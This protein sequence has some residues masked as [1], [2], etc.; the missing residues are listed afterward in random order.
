[1]RPRRTTRPETFLIPG[2]ILILSAL[3]LGVLCW[4]M[5]LF[6]KMSSSSQPVPSL[7]SPTG[8]SINPTLGFTQGPVSSP[9]QPERTLAPGA[10]LIGV[11]TPSYALETPGISP[12]SSVD[13]EQLVAKM[14]LEEKVGQ[15]IMT[16]LEG[17]TLSAEAKSL[18]RD[19]HI[20]GV[21]YFGHNIQN[22]QQ[23]LRL[24]QDLQREAAAAG[25]GIPLLIAVDHEGGSVFRFKDS[26]THFP[27]AMTLGAARMPELARQVGIAQARELR[28][29]GVNLNLAPVMD[30]NDEPLNPVIGVRALAGIPDL[31]AQVGVAYLQGLQ[32]AGVAATA[33]HFPGHGSTRIDSHLALAVVNKSADELQRTDLVPFRAAVEAGVE[34][35]MVGHI[36]V[37]AVDASR[38]PASLSGPILEGLLRQ[39]LSYRGVVMSDAM[40]MGAVTGNYSLEEAAVRAVNAGCDIL[41]YTSSEAALA[42]HKAVLAAVRNGSIPLEKVDASVRRILALKQR[43][44]LFGSLPNTQ[45]VDFAAD[46]ALAKFLAHQAIAASGP[47]S[48][49][50]V[51]VN[52]LVL[53]TPDNLPV[54]NVRGD[55]LSLLGE[56]LTRQGLE[57]DE[58]IYSLE[59]PAQTAQMQGLTMV[60]LR[61][62]PLAV[63]VTWDARLKQEGGNS[64]QVEFVQALSRSGKPFILVAGN[65]PYDLTLTNGKGLALFGGLSYQ[66]EALAEAF[67]APTAPPGILPVI[68]R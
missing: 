18:I 61:N 3:F 37:P 50:L 27:N 1:M 11:E 8:F 48:F 59:D 26:L 62:Y 52:R 15:M 7:V 49:P 68:L 28:S 34:V 5:A 55:G 65:S 39:Q 47:L 46:Q 42:G 32:T 17:Q 35:V 36:A 33:K 56:L 21:V 58:Y 16:G 51:N 12:T 10:P 53:V 63:M 30:V 40:G 38:A 20:G 67:L 64:S 6:L 54:G 4:G 45:E 41:A 19:Y 57:V 24:S 22:A 2:V 29:V 13:L 31:A 25:L 44:G 43:L 9:T 23:T 14:S 66:I 60:A